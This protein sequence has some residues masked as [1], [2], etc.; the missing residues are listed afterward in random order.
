M[1]DTVIRRTNLVGAW[2]GIAY[3]VLLFVGWWVIG[4]FFPLH[5]PAAG[6]EEIAAFFR[7]NSVRVRAGMVIVMWGAAVFMPFVA[8]VADFVARFEGRNGP[9]TR[10]FTMAGYANAML[11]FYPPLWWIINSFR[12][13]ERSPDLVYLLNDIAWLQFLGGITLILP[14]YVVIAVV[15]LAD[16]SEHPVFPRWLGYLSIVTFLGFIPDQLM[17]FFKVGP[18]AWNGVL[19]FWIPLTVFCAWFIGVFVVVRRAVLAE[20]RTGEESTGPLRPRADIGGTP[21]DD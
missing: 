1:H 21:H 4:G 3:M 8:A 6:A 19:G 12:A 16:K 18:I 15:A 11:T 13:S 14:M 17:Y 2:S 5:S 20:P 9:L 10:T 7:D